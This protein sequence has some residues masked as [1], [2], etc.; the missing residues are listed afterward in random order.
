M[1]TSVFLKEKSANQ[2]FFGTRSSA[3]PLREEL[4]QLL[5]GN[6]E[7]MLDFAGVEATQSFIDELVGHLVLRHGPDLLSL[8]IFKS[9]S[10][11]LKAIIQFVISD[12]L[13]Q[14]NRL[15]RH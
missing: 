3:R 1:R 4:G 7:V 8:L 10:D 11:E 14:F 6:N 15:H 12:R 9:C 2:R 5:A 13:D